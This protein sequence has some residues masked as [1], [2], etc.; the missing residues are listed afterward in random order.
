MRHSAI[1]VYTAASVPQCGSFECWAVQVISATISRTSKHRLHLLVVGCLSLCLTYFANSALGR[2]LS[3]VPGIAAS[4]LASAT[5]AL[6][7]Y[8]SIRPNRPFAWVV[9]STPWNNIFRLSALWLSAWLL[10]SIGVGM[11]DGAWH[12]YA[13]GLLPVLGFVI[14]GPLSEELFL[15]GAI[16][17]LAERSFP[18]SSM[19]PIAISTA[20]FSAY[21]LQIHAFKLTP[22]VL[23][24]LGF[25]LPLGYVLASLRRWSGS[26]WPGLVLH[27]LTNLPHAIGLD[28]IT[29]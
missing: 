6:A 4:C 12:A 2:A 17:E 13:I 24:Q 26:L 15:R 22:F 28:P 16:F 7:V 27:I 8:V 20:L 14:F 11:V 25:T 18:S 1:L 9:D 19:A 29:S 3:S 21:H 23:M 5:V 10:G